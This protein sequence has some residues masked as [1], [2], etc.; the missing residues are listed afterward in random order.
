MFRVLRL[1]SIPARIRHVRP[2]PPLQRDLPSRLYT[3]NKTQSHDLT[4][5]LE[6]PEIS[7]PPP[8]PELPPPVKGW[9]TFWIHAKDADTYLYPL[10][11]RGWGV[12]F[13]P[14][15]Y[16][17]PHN[18]R[19]VAHL[20]TDF[21]L[22]NYNCASQFLSDITSICQEEK[23]HLSSFSLLNAAGQ[24]P[25][26]TV[27]IQT[28]TAMR[29]RWNE[30]DP[31]AD[32]PLSRRVPGITRRDMRLALRIEKLYDAYQHSGKALDIR[33]RKIRQTWET[34]KWEYLISRF[35][36]NTLNDPITSPEEE[37][38]KLY[39]VIA[40]S[41]DK[42]AVDATHAEDLIRFR[43][44][45]YARSILPLLF[46]IY[47]SSRIGGSTAPLDRVTVP[48]ELLSPDE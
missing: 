16:Y 23:H 15:K 48:T 8:L 40:A 22:C 32:P 24:R 25:V 13:L 4:S 34:P 46:V 2:I 26:L 41:S 6:A 14:R 44:A 18:D 27:F 9:P 31:S 3:T 10:Y 17:K 47:A 33:G 19:Y 7:A 42:E 35:I 38:E 28:H 43:T 29:P 11:S 30:E 21:T 1:S 37:N 20:T 12:R 36:R 39:Q 5:S 45:K